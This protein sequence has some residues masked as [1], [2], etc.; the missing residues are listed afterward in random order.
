VTLRSLSDGFSALFSYLQ[1][2]LF[3]PIE[4]AACFL[5][6]GKVD[7]TKQQSDVVQKIIKIPAAK[8]WL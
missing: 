4:D 8:K 7:F 5:C 6:V 1:M 2:L 3:F